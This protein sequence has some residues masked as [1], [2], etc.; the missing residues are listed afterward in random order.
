MANLYLWA[1]RWNIPSEAIHDLIVEMGISTETD[2]PSGP[3]GSES[4]AQT[5]VRLEASEKGYRLWRNNVGA[6]T[7][8]ESGS[9]LRWGLCNDSKSM[10]KKVK[11]HD[12]IG[13]KPVLITPEMV[14]TTIGQFLSREMKRPGWRYQ[15]TEEERAQLA[16]G[17]IVL[18]LGGDAAFA[19][20]RGTL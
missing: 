15:G 6:G 11:S 13:I 20:G 19:T 17:Q 2:V 12:L 8:M 4:A 3:P 5:D 14:G 10:N 7:I 18:S 1:K 16:F 9:F